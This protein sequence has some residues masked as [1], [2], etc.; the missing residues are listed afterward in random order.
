MFIKNDDNLCKHC[1]I[2]EL[3]Y[4]WCKQCETNKLRENFTN[5]SSGNEIIDVFIREKQLEI[6]NPWDNVFEWIP[7]N[8]FINIKK[9]DDDEFFTIYS[10]KWEDGPLYWYE[11]SKIYIRIPEEIALKHSYNIQNVNEF[12]NEV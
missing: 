7:Y 11:Y 4:N 5:W 1:L 8:K 10:A 12:L 2:T 3:Y 6:I 9:V